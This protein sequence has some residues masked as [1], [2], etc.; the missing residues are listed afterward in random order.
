MGFWL[1]TY[2][3]SGGL[4]GGRQIPSGSFTGFFENLTSLT[5]SGNTIV[6]S[7]YHY[8][9][10]YDANGAEGWSGAFGTN[11]DKIYTYGT[12]HMGDGDHDIIFYEFTIPNPEGAQFYKQTLVI[13]AR[14][15]ATESSGHTQAGDWHRMNENVNFRRMYRREYA[16]PTSVPTTTDIMTMNVSYNGQYL[17]PNSWATF[18]TWRTI[19][20]RFSMGYH[21]YSNSN[22][23]VFC[24]YHEL[25][26]PTSY[27]DPDTGDRV[28]GDAYQYAYGMFGIKT[29]YLD[30]I[31]GD[32]KLD[33]NDDPNVDPGDDDDPGDDPTPGPGEREKEYDPIPIPPTPELTAIGSGFLTLYTP[34]AT[35][36]NLL[37][38]EIFSDNILQIIANY[39]TSISDI[40]AG[41]S[42]V[43]FFVPT[44]GF[45]YHK[46]GLFESSV[47]LPLVSSQF[48]DVDC[49]SVNVKRFF[50]NFL[51][52]APSTKIL[53]YLPYIGYQELNTDEVM[54]N[55]ISVKY[56]C[57]I[58]SGA[59]VAYVMIGSG[60]E[61]HE[62][63]RI[64]A[65]FSGNVITQVPTASEAYDSMVSNAINILTSSVGIAAGAAIGGGIGSGAMTAQATAG[66]SQAASA[67]G[68][69]VG[70][71]MG[72][73]A[74]NMVMSMKPTFS[75]NGTPGSTAGYMSYQKP[76]LIKIVPRDAVAKNHIQLKGYP[77]NYGGPLSAL[78]GYCEVS[79]IQLQG[80]N[81][82]VDEITEI[83][84]LLKGGVVV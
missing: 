51:D 42:I 44:S 48:I 14:V 79:E 77:S 5:A 35:A 72:G 49:G 9:Y 15:T 64:I 3:P 55:V 47:S 20:L 1:K 69:Q 21:E 13:E 52:Q 74:A 59:C 30:T 46:I 61:G 25:E 75:R 53:I 37:A 16:T 4:Y 28:S 50:N 34:S 81:A 73:T 43:P 62:A 39:F 65:Q 12:N 6:G 10:P 31:F 18:T 29:S 78:S 67:I 36:L 24:F 58:L 57:D 66:S 68:A 83:Y 11:D 54:A 32:F 7:G 22:Y 70:M 19:N 45:A 76:Y 71:G 2:I 17:L 63:S 56:R 60:G 82:T 80:V 33:E 23:L 41:L 84:S 27:I 38:D 8:N 40:I 26:Q